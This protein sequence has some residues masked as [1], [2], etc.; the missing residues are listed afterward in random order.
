MG[1]FILIFHHVGKQSFCSHFAEMGKATKCQ[2]HSGHQ[3]LSV[4]RASPEPPAVRKVKPLRVRPWKEFS[5]CMYL[6]VQHLLLLSKNR[7]FIQIYFVL[8]QR[9]TIFE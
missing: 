5:H 1:Y 7:T 2:Q 4:M 3:A 6:S 8:L 9:E